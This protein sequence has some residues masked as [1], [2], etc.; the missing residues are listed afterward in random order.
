[1]MANV[2]G[3]KDYRAFV[4]PS[5]KYDLVGAMQFNLLTA[6]GLREYH[7]LL[8]IGCGSLRAGRLF[9]PYLLPGRY[10]GIEPNQWLIE[11]GIRNELGDDLVRI[12]Q[13]SF[14]NDDNF[15]LTQFGRKF[16]Y[17]IA[18]S[19]F[20]HASQEQIKRCLSQAREVMEP[21]SSFFAA[22]FNRGEE[23]YMGNDWVYPGFV[24]YSLERITELATEEGLQCQSIEWSH[25]NGQSWVV[26]TF[27]I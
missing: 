22:T 4:G 14:S 5:E 1:M 13:P 18:Q 16:D 6:I 27:P 10:F 17:I 7:Y 15:T 2:P 24:T 20:S 3:V 26:F 19:I 12:K 9:I 23:N 21:R 8:D 25:P 11:E